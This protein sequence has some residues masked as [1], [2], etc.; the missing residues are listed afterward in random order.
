[1]Q[2]DIYDP[3]RSRRALLCAF[4]LSDRAQPVPIRPEAI[5]QWRLR[6][7]T[8]AEGYGGAG[9]SKLADIIPA[10][11]RE[12]EVTDAPKRL[13]EPSIPEQQLRTIHM[14]PWSAA[15]YVRDFSV[16]VLDLGRAP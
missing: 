12:L 15:V 8:D 14:P 5:G 7:T 10:L 6:L 16:D 11:E 13:L 2:N 3:E 4:N 1:V 9:A